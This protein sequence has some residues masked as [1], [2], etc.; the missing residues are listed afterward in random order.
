MK[1]VKVI[2]IYSTETQN[3][4]HWNATTMSLQV[5]LNHVH[6]LMLHLALG[7]EATAD[8]ASQTVH[9]TLHP[10]SD[11][12][13]SQLTELSSES[14]C[15]GSSFSWQTPPNGLGKTWG[16][17]QAHNPVMLAWRRGWLEGLPQPHRAVASLLHCVPSQQLEPGWL[18]GVK[19][20]AANIM[21]C[22][23]SDINKMSWHFQGCNSLFPTQ[24]YQS[25]VMK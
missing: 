18:Q 10:L 4:S 6:R 13:Q 20:A 5:V 9:L 2:R 24:R 15:A 12:Q 23:L 22:E 7:T 16:C 1:I 19:W 17:Q 8:Q 3:A 11:F 14:W 21:T 25:R